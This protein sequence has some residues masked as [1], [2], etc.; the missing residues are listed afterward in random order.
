VIAWTDE[1][2]LLA[3]RRLG[4]TDAIIEA[5]TENHGRHAGVVKGGGGRRMAPVLQPGAQLSIEW[6]A[7]LESHL[8]T[9]RVEPI[10]ARAGAIMADAGA[11][12]A[13]TSAAALLGAFLPE[14]APHPALYARTVALFDTLAGGGEWGAAYARWEL[15]LLAELGFGLDLGACAA[16]GARAD[17]VFVSPRTGRAVSR[18][19]GGPYADR[20]LALPGFLLRDAAPG[21]GDVAA[22]LRLTGHFLGAW[23]AAAAGA[24]AAPAARLR[25]G[26]RFGL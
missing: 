15:A 11:L 13:L 2:A 26:A 23:V 8:G 25:L 22:A 6:R 14:R 10:R 7:R 19:A 9:A 12:A 1:G 4:E 3:V 24:E 16:T 20:L 21:P 17:L 18:E 5:L